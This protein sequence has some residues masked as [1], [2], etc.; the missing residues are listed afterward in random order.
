[1]SDLTAL[2]LTT[3]FAF[4][5]VSFSSVLVVNR[6]GTWV[7]KIARQIASPS[8]SPKGRWERRISNVVATIALGFGQGTALALIPWNWGTASVSVILILAAEPVLA[9]A[10]TVYLARAASS[11]QV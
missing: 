10:W 3:A 2:A 5:F 1:M 7:P 4:W 9:V 11:R 6:G 8:N